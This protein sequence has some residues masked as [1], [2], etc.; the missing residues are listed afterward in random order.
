MKAASN[1]FLHEGKC[2]GLIVS[3]MEVIIFV[4]AAFK[5]RLSFMCFFCNY[6][7][8]FCDTFCFIYADSKPL[9]VTTFSQLERDVILISYGSKFDH[10]SLLYY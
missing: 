9:D 5:C 7:F 3:E 10:Y 4:M 6:V 2:I 1:W 8:V